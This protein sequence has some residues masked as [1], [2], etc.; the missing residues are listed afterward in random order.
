MGEIE[1]KRKIETNSFSIDKCI[2]RF[3]FFK[4]NYQ[5]I[6]LKN[7]NRLPDWIDYRVVHGTVLIDVKHEGLNSGK[8]KV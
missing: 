3:S 5:D 4:L 2:D 6:E 1:V 7:N 8:F